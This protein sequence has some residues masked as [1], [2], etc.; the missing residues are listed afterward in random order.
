MILDKD[1]TN[2]LSEME[3]G[4]FDSGDMLEKYEDLS[5]DNRRSFLKQTFELLKERNLLLE[6]NKELGKQ[7]ELG[8]LISKIVSRTTE[9]L[10]A[11]R[12]SLFLI[13]CQKDELYSK[14][15]QGIDFLEIRFPISVGIAGHVARTGEI[16]NLEDVYQHPLF[17][18]GIDKSTGYRTKSMLCMP[19][20]NI[21][22]LNMGVIQVI[23]KKRGVFTHRDIEVLKSLSRPLSLALENAILYEDTKASQKKIEALLKVANSLSSALDLNS[24]FS[25]IM[26][27]AAELLSADRSSLFLIDNE[28]NELWSSVVAGAE[29]KEI[30]FPKHLG[31]AGQV[32]TTGKILNIPD[33]YDFPGFNKDIDKKTGYRTKSILCMPI[34]G[35]SNQ[36]IG[37]TQVIN[38]STGVFNHSDEEM[39]GAFSAQ[40]AISLQNSQLFEKTVTMK[41][42]LEAMLSSLS[43]GVITLDHKRRVVKCNPVSAKIFGHKNPEDLQGNNFAELLGCDNTN[44]LKEVE[45]VFECK[46]SNSL[47][48]VDY[49]KPCG[50]K[51]S[52]NIAAVPLMDDAGNSLGIVLVTEDITKEKRVKSNLTRYMSK[53][54]VEKLTSGNDRLELG[55]TKREVT[56]LFSD[57]RGYTSLTEKLGPNEIVEMLNEYFTHM[58]DAIF[59]YDGVLD[60]F[61]GDAIM[62]VFGAPVV[63]PDHALKSVNAALEMKTALEG[64]NAERIARGKVPIQIGIG[65]STGEVLCG[66]I[67]SDKRMEYTS[68]GDGVNLSSRLESATKLYRAMTLLSEFT[69]EQVKGHVFTR[70]LDFIRV[71]GKRKP[72]RIYQLLGQAGCILDD[73]TMKT[74]ESFSIG[75]ELFFRRDFRSAHKSFLKALEYDPNDLPST[76]YLHRCE[77]CIETPPPEDWDGV[78]DLKEK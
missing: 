70:E 1:L 54:L 38:K 16:L 56:I 59:K 55:G 46:Q 22:G 35:L 65:I 26:A 78:Y 39:L 75:H 3:S 14:V 12:S 23:N 52:L 2:L 13:D 62:A 49:R 9:I 41:K 69:Y 72:V 36:I 18:Q 67:G 57:I 40:A 28:T 31:I 50:E 27:K 32:A 33:A 43:N 53:D 63:F 6:I 71:K 48:D 4:H 76:L 37:V 68:I 60:K 10:N 29:V 19:I 74:V 5:F 20:T 64:F 47:Y 25:T 58:V 45:K 15:A 7:L 34:M 17:N 66:N 8:P 44:I 77:T 30:R 21:A 61:I 24:L 73:T 51:I 11:D 42:Y